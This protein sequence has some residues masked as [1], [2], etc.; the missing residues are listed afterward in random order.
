MKSI[1]I[2]GRSIVLDEVGSVTPQFDRDT[3]GIISYEVVLSSGERL[4]VSAPEGY[5][6]QIALHRR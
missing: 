3:A 6:L 5:K 1:R 4:S 2:A